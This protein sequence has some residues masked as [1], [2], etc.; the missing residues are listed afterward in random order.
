MKTTLS[1]IINLNNLVVKV[2]NNSFY[3][4]DI[5]IENKQIKF[6]ESSEYCK[7]FEDICENPSKINN[8]FNLDSFYEIYGFSKYYQ[9]KNYI[10]G[11]L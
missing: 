11:I 8:I 1:H 10:L 2:Y 3:I 9:Y 6:I 5:E 4:K 7:I